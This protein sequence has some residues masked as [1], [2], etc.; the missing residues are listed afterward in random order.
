MG[1][2]KQNT[3]SSVERKHKNKGT[4]P[5]RR[6]RCAARAANRNHRNRVSG[7]RSVC[8]RF[9]VGLLRNGETQLHLGTSAELMWSILDC[10]WLVNA[11]SMFEANT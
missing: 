5:E 8:V 7:R 9:A 2:R 10:R 11:Q 4:P 3:S 1:R 6:R